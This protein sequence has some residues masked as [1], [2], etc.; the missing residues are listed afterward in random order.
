MYL[1]D[2]LFVFVAVVSERKKQ[3]VYSI[4]KGK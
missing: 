1:N 4:N 3:K 2:L